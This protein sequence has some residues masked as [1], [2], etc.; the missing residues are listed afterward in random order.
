M[1]DQSPTPDELLGYFEKL[2][3]WGRWG[4]DDELGAIN[5]ITPEKVRSAAQLVRTGERISCARPL[6]EAP[7]IP[8]LPGYVKLM[9]SSGESWVAGTG[10]PELWGD[11]QSSGD[12]FGMPVHGYH[13]H[14]DAPSHVFRDGKMYNGASA[15][16][17]TTQ[18]GATRGAVDLVHDGIVSRGVLFDFPRLMGK[19]YL[20]RGEAIHRADLEAAEREMGVTVSAGDIVLLRTGK[21]ARPG[22]SAWDDGITVTPEGV[23]LGAKPGLHADT[24]PWIRER[25]LSALICDD[26]SDLSPSGY[27]IVTPV[28]EFCLVALGVWLVDTADFERLAERCEEE[29]R[30]ECLM[31]LSPLRLHNAT[32][33]PINPIAVL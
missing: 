29:K 18:Q 32:G 24:L 9:I 26:I 1:P 28:H 21:W 30:W 7:G 10:K 23:S 20:E 33:S 27:D 14:L 19:S 6:A 15:G 11:S 12:W 17:V 31:M 2:N 22:G 13:T 25:D 4:S 8:G 16:L 3:N 5:L